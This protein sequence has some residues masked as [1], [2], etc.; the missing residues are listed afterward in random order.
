MEERDSI[1]ENIY[2]QGKLSATIKLCVAI[3]GAFEM[4]AYHVLDTD[5]FL[6]HM[7]TLITEYEQSLELALAHSQGVKSDPGNAVEAE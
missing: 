6:E 4:Y 7:Q 3:K 2:L 1:K 5:A